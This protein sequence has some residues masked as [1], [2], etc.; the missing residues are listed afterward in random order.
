MFD[1]RPLHGE[2]PCRRGTKAQRRQYRRDHLLDGRRP[3]DGHRWRE[4]ES[5]RH[6]L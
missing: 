2:Y 3:L 6:S 1:R 5:R 4:T